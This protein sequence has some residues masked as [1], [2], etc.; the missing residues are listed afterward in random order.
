MHYFDSRGVF[1][2]HNVS[3]DD[4]GWRLWRDAPEF[5][6]RFTGT[7][8]D[9]GETIDG[10]WQLCVDNVNWNNDLQITYRLCH[11]AS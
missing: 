5:S 6:Q 9:D 3:I 4:R 8:A 2:I 10:H 11:A 7:F 1:R